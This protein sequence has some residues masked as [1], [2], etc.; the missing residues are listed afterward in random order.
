MNTNDLIQ[1]CQK[2]GRYFAAFQHAEKVLS[3]LADAENR[4]A[5]TISENIKA[6]LASYFSAG[7]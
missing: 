2:L 5:K 6:R 7:A 3:A 4:A 1:E